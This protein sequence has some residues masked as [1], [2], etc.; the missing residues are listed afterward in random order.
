MNGELMCTSCGLCPSSDDDILERLYPINRERTKWNFHCSTH[1][2]GCGR[3]VYA[4]TRDAVV[5]RWK[6]GVTDEVIE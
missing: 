5:K 2:G 4:D 1:Y 6:S 3:T